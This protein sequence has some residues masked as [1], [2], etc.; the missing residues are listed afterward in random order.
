MAS[1]TSSSS[2]TPTSDSSFRQRPRP[3][4][5]IPWKK[6]YFLLKNRDLSAE[7]EMIELLDRKRSFRVGFISTKSCKNIWEG[8]CKFPLIVTFLETLTNNS[9]EEPSPWSVVALLTLVCQTVYEVQEIV[10]CLTRSSSCLVHDVLECFYCLASIF[11]Y[12]ES[13]HR[14]GSGLH[15]RVFYSLYLY[16]NAFEATCAS[17]GSVFDQNATGQQSMMRYRSSTDKLQLTHEQVRI[18]KHDV[19]A[20]EIIKI[21]AFAGTGKTT[22]LVEY[23]KM[24]PM[25]KFLNVAYNKSIQQHALTLFPSNVESRTIHSL[26]FRSVGYRYKHKLAFGLRISSI[27]NALSGQMWVSARETS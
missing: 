21:V 16:E 1:S 7:D 14:I 19:K 25:E 9:K 24:R 5:F 8:H 6:K 22:T 27:M 17:I 18:I 12:L 4:K 20:G 15:Y 2:S 11:Y 23:T 13:Q 3:R 26:A 10:N